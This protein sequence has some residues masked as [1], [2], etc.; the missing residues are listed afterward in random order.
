M[1]PLRVDCLT[2][3]YKGI[4]AVDQLS[5]EIAPHQVTVWLGPNGSGKTTLMRML[6]G[7]LSPD[8]GTITLFGRRF[9]IGD[10]AANASIGYCPQKLSIWYDLTVYE[11]LAYLAD[12]YGLTARQKFERIEFLLN[13]LK[14]EEKA[15]VTGGKLSGG[16]QRRVN[17]ALALIHKPQ[18]LVLDEPFNGLDVTSRLLV[19]RLVQSLAH[20][21]KVT[22][23]LTTHD[24]NDAELFADRINIMHQGRLL[25]AGSSGDLKKKLQY[26]QTIK[27]TF[28]E[29]LDRYSSEMNSLLGREDVQG[30]FESNT[31][32]LEVKNPNRLVQLLSEISQRKIEVTSI[33]AS[34]PTLED[35]F[36][37]LT[38]GSLQ[39]VS[40]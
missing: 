17:L 29:N 19:R 16:M 24:I 10:Q 7:L 33:V 32:T 1:V 40:D 6:C 25:A 15:R 38:G 36:I 18:L 22:T 31:L 39:H 30:S 8:S 23:V 13:T 12:I 9:Q 11:Q 4:T 2:K 5:F 3:K 35:L 14:L 21:D 27:I 20:E 28:L 37:S 26:Q 34:E